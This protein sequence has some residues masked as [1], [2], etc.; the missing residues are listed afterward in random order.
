MTNWKGQLEVIF[1]HEVLH[2]WVPNALQLRGDY[3]WFF[4]GFTLYTALLTALDLK[5]I[6]FREYL[7]TLA[8]VYDSYISYPNVLSLI[9][10]HHS[11]SARSVLNPEENQPRPEHR[12]GL[13]AAKVQEQI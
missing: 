13:Q 8:R 12:K 2:L 11:R 10:A 1:S 4:E 5:A 6:D 7:D 9:E 3:D